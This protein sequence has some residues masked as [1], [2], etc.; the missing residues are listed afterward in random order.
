[1]E[2]YIDTCTL[3]SKIDEEDNVIFQEV[4]FQKIDTLFKEKGTSISLEIGLLI[5]S[6]TILVASILMMHFF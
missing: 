6:Y 2:E 1:M 4:V 3:I 5:L